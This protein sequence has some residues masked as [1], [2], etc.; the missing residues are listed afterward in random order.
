MD[1]NENP[2]TKQNKHKLKLK[3]IISYKKIRKGKNSSK[4]RL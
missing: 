1:Q 3:D 4:W 2:Y